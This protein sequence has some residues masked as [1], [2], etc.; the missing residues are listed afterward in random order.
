MVRV[1]R[2]DDF[3]KI[4]DLA[5]G[6]VVDIDFS[7]LASIYVSFNADIKDYFYNN[8]YDA[9]TNISIIIDAIDDK[10][11]FTALS[12][13]LKLGELYS[14]TDKHTIN[15]MRRPNEIIW[16]LEN[17]PNF[18]SGS[19]NFDNATPNDHSLFSILLI[20][21]INFIN[22]QNM[23]KLRYNKKEGQR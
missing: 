3:I 6:D 20:T 8:D 4:V 18:V 13:Y 11:L 14:W 21:L 17:N 2:E 23:K 16:E 10:D 9:R 7:Y 19:V 5:S 15:I 1:T 12:C 22:C